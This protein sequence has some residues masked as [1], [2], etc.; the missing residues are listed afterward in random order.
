MT[1]YDIA[2]IDVARLRPT[3]EVKAARVD[4]LMKQ[5][6]MEGLQRRPILVERDS[7]AILDGHHRYHAA[8]QLGLTRIA[9]VLIAY[10][11]AR[12]SLQS[13]TSRSYSAADVL[14]AAASQQLLPAKST[15]HV[16][17]PPL[18][19][20]PVRLDRLGLVRA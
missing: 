19:D 16:L 17:E 7:L 9:A 5:M 2:L 1:G 11:D 8:L 4:R 20:D 6:R 13:W 12:L 10:G 3:E 18:P 14:A 15:R